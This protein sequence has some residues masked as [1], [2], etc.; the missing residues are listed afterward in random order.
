MPT[1]TVWPSS[2]PI[3][4]VSR[5]RGVTVV[6]VVAASTGSAPSPSAVAVSV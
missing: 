3:D 5:V 6:K 1:P 2:G 4:G